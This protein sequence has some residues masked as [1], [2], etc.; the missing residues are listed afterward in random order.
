MHSSAEPVEGRSGQ[1]GHE[2][3]HSL[4]LAGID[5]KVQAVLNERTLLLER[6]D[7]KGLRIALSQIDRIRHHHVGVIPPGV[8]LMGILTLILS[9]R[10]LTGDIQLYAAAAGALTTLTWLLG[11]R[12]ALFIETSVGDRHILYAG[13][14]V[15][16]RMQ[17][18]VNR[19]MDGQTLDEAR[20]GLDDLS[21]Q[22]NFPT[23]SAL[24]QLVEQ[25]EVME[26]AILEDEVAPQLE[27]DES[28]LES[29]LSRFYGEKEQAPVPIPAPV[30][31]AAPSGGLLARASEAHAAQPATHTA[32]P[33]TDPWNQPEPQSR[34]QSALGAAVDVG[35]A[36]PFNF[37]MFDDPAPVAEPAQE[38]VFGSMFDTPSPTPAPAPA[39]APAPMHAMVPT[40]AEPERPTWSG[41]ALRE[42]MV[43]QGTGLPEPSAAAVRQE[44]TPGIVAQARAMSSMER[45]ETETGLPT[46]TAEAAPEENELEAYP[47]FA[48]LLSGE[49]R[50]RLRPAQGRG[51]ML[52][53]FAR[54]GMAVIRRAEPSR[55]VSAIA[56]RARAPRGDDYASVYGDDDGDAQ[57]LFREHNLRSG[58][59]LR[60]RADQDHQAQIAEQIREISRSNGGDMEADAVDALVASLS[61]SGD[62]ESVATLLEGARRPQ[63]SFS[64]MSSTSPA[65]EEPGHHGIQRLA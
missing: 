28:E 35:V 31:V 20:E 60:L 64:S 27:I 32:Q 53:R 45:D 16:L 7:G 55:A 9:A 26:A 11:R 21:A 5:G 14:S 57:G 54:R 10:V 49:P 2:V 56:T 15:L 19:L 13:D 30:P 51:G 63:L 48:R 29:A 18:L 12:P 33:A 36:D 37:G 22:S 6:A 44:C 24:H 25:E 1:E 52:S 17:L 39:P 41:A 4:R 59:I 34:I 40:T 50:R 8:T 62:L 46:P 23:I 61:A 42:A 3:L 58:Q 38:S 65:E 47:T 43:H